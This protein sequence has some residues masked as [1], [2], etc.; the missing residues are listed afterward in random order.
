M[1]LTKTILS[2]VLSCAMFT[3]CGTTGTSV[4]YDASKGQTVYESGEM[5][6]AQMDA[7]VGSGSSIVMQAVATCEGQN[8]TPDRAQLVFSVRG[9]NEVALARRSISIVADGVE[10]AAQDANEWGGRG[11]ISFSDEP[12]VEV[13]LS[14]SAL[15]QI[16]NASSL[17]A[18]LGNTSLNVGDGDQEELRTFVQTAQNPESS[19]EAS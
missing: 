2:V 12:V 19:A 5:S 15:E 11:D 7:A 16:A 13:D 1:R 3:A 6:V 17:S 4:S 18:R 10:Y 8:C 14:L 9:R